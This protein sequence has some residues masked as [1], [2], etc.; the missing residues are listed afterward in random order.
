MICREEARLRDTFTRAV[1]ALPGVLV[2]RSEVI[3][4]QQ[5][6]RSL[7]LGHP[8]LVFLA[9]GRVILIEW[10]APTGRLEPEQVA[11]HRAWRAAGGTVL[12]CCDPAEAC[13]TVAGLLQEPESTAVREAGKKIAQSVDSPL[14]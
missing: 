7:P 9:A 8:D 3:R 11:F 1:G 10:K 6:Q 4:G 12:V 5:K 14:L 2:Y 13:E